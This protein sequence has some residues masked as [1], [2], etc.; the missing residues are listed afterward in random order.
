M[1]GKGEVHV[2]GDMVMRVCMPPL[3]KFMECM[4]ATAIPPTPFK[5]RGGTS[6][7]SYLVK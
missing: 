6:K 5:I 4:L 7:I 1:C 3:S 2:E